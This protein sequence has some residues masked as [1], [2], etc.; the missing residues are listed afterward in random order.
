MSPEMLEGELVVRG[1]GAARIGRAIATL[2]PIS[3][4]RRL[5]RAALC[6][7][8]GLILAVLFLPIPIMHLV[9]IALGIPGG[10]YLAS[11]QLRIGHVL[12]K[13]E[14]TCPFCGQRQAFWPGLGVLGFRLPLSVSCESCHRNLTVTELTPGS[15]AA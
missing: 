2:E 13:L 1:A 7:G 4:R 8:A 15:P 12:R 10:I 14:G 3:P 11:R 5:G 9:G 6:A